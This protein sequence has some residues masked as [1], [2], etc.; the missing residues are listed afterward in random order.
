M[1]CIVVSD[2]GLRIDAAFCRDTK[3]NGEHRFCV[4]VLFDHPP[5]ASWSSTTGFQTLFNYLT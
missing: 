3:G 1:L 5:L 2:S 4:F